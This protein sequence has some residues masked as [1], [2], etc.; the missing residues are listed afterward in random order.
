LPRLLTAI[1]L[2]FVLRGAFYCRFIPLWEGYDEWGHYAFVEH[3]R[4]NAGSLPHTTDGVTEEIR[5]SVQSAR[6]LHEAADPLKLFEA[7]QPPLYYWL[8]SIPNRFVLPTDIATRILILRLFSMWIA[9]LAIPFGYL[10]ALE[11]FHSRSIALSICALITAMPELM[12]DIARIGNE[13]L[14]IAIA[15]WLILLLLRKR[16]PMLGLALGLGLLTKA[17]FLAFLPILIFKRRFDSLAAA[18]AI[19]GW[20][21]WRNILLTGTLTGEIMDVATKKL[22]WTAKLAAIGNQHWLRALDTALWTH[23]WSGAWSFFTV[24]SWMYRVFEL[25]FALLAVL[26]LYAIF[27]APISRTKGKLRML[28]FLE[29]LFIAGIA[30]QSL[31]IFQNTG[32]SF[33]PGW[34]FYTLVVAEAILLATGLFVLVGRRRVVP[35]I[36]CL[37]ALFASLDLYSTIFVLA[38]H[39]KG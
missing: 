37:T 16:A 28:V 22:G 27:K 31:A 19:S 32:L 17:Y 38:R 35:A 10:A 15:S 18:L 36:L 14:S 13:S 11:V 23:I 6:F 24:K 7:Q 20:W 26:V 12:I 4:T 21:Y 8:L 5:R 30:Y 9:S 29:A 39:Y 25:I 33:A 1:W 2:V 34:Y 3:L